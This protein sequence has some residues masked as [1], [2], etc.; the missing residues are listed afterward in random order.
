MGGAVLFPCSPHSLP[1]TPRAAQSRHQHVS[2][3]NRFPSPQHYLAFPTSWN[4]PNPPKVR[5][6]PQTL[7][8]FQ[9]T[10]VFHSILKK[11]ACTRCGNRWPPSTVDPRVLHAI[12]AGDQLGHEFLYV[13]ISFVNS[14]GGTKGSR[15][16][17][18]W[19]WWSAVV[20]R[21]KLL[22]ADCIIDSSQTKF[23]PGFTYIWQLAF[24]ANVD[25]FLCD[26][27]SSAR[28][29]V[30][31]RQLYC[32]DLYVFFFFPKSLYNVVWHETL[33]FIAQFLRTLH[34]YTLQ[35]GPM[36]W[37]RHSRDI[38]KPVNLNRTEQVSR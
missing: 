18:L 15:F 26:D 25:C 2:L 20:T 7:S 31:S 4:S 16:H 34:W 24:I 36:A 29:K 11:Q 8:L 5:I 27:P 10:M 17:G 38:G 35:H 32:F 12:C 21:K 30:V 33:I 13:L 37:S 28:T 1:A 19:T 14:V 3:L 23:L 6:L 22:E 9:N